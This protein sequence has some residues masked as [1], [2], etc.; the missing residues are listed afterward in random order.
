MAA[1]AASILLLPLLVLLPHAHLKC[2]K[3]DISFF[4]AGRTSF[5]FSG[6]EN[7]VG[8]ALLMNLP[9]QL[10]IWWMKSGTMSQ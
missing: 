8:S 6:L 4:K 9:R 10:D 3:E 7:L 5:V 1:I 2:N